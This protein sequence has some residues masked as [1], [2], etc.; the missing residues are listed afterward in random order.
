MLFLYSVMLDH[1]Y[2]GD[3]VPS[4]PLFSFI[5]LYISPPLCPCNVDRSMRIMADS[6]A[7]IIPPVNSAAQR[8]RRHYWCVRLCCLRVIIRPIPISSLFSPPFL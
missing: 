4:P 3:P 7:V 6:S 2:M 1:H 5:L 8:T